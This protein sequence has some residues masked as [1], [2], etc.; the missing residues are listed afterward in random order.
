MV[1]IVLLMFS[2]FNLLRQSWPNEEI[3]NYKQTSVGQ[4][5]LSTTILIKLIQQ[6]LKSV[7]AKPTWESRITVNLN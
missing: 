3:I 4:N 6:V 1:S 2:Q 5:F 7:S